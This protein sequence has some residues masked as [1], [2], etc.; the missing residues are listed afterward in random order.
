MCILI[1]KPANMD[2]PTNDILIECW[3]N[4]PDGFG[5]CFH[6]SNGKNV[7]NKGILNCEQHI[8]LIDTMREMLYDKPV[9]LHYRMATLGSVSSGNCHPFP[10]SP[11][12]NDLKQTM[13]RTNMSV[14]AHNGVISQFSGIQTK[15]DL[16]DTMMFVK[17]LYHLG[18]K[19]PLI[20]S[21]LKLG[22]Y[23]IMHPDGS[24]S[25]YGHFVED[26]GIFYSN[27][28]YKE[29]KSYIIS[30]DGI[31]DDYD[32]YWMEKYY[33]NTKRYGEECNNEDRCNESGLCVWTGLPID[34]EIDDELYYGET[35]CP[36][37]KRMFMLEKPSTTTIKPINRKER[38]KM[39]SNNRNRINSKKKDV[40][41]RNNLN[42]INRNGKVL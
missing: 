33:S 38:R 5:L 26:G 4:N 34:E 11:N 27:T 31:C 23:C 25:K 37:V 1:Y 24:V 7:I 21:I 40:E 20:Q 30:Y 22:K 36:K 42:K 14:M 41:F 19:D 17:R 2:L 28:S 12:V 10:I 3:K 18:E 29:M 6:S 39:L 15:N 9:I 13:L 8:A 32:Q 35:Y 16:S